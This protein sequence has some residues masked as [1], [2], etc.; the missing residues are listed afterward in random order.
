MKNIRLVTWVQNGNKLLQLPK[1]KF[2][3]RC[4]ARCFTL[5]IRFKSFSIGLRE[6][7]AVFMGWLVAARVLG[8]THYAAFLTQQALCLAVVLPAFPLSLFALEN[9]RYNRKTNLARAS[10]WQ[11]TRADAEQQTSIPTDTRPR[12]KT[13]LHSRNAEGRM[14]GKTF[15]GIMQI[16]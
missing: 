13:G 10:E 8:Q 1:S 4:S 11:R 12:P 7:T 3:A 5:V 14:W 6:E 15:G 2:I 16:N 9:E